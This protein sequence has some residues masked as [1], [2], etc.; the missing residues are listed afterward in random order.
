MRTDLE[1]HGFEHPR[2][3]EGAMPSDRNRLIVYLDGE[4]VP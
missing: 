2:R 3:E 4:F 1:I